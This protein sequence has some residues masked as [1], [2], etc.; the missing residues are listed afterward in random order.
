MAGSILRHSV[1]LGYACCL[2]LF[3]VSAVHAD[4]PEI[5]AEAPDGLQEAIAEQPETADL[6]AEAEHE[7]PA[8]PSSY[9]K[10]SGRI[11]KARS[12]FVYART[13]VGT[14]TLFSDPGLRSARAGQTVTL[15]T[16]DR[17]VVVDLHNKGEPTPILRLISGTPAHTSPEQQEV[18]FWTPEGGQL[19]PL[20]GDRGKLAPR[21]DGAPVTLQLK[22]SGE[23]VELPELHVDI[24]IS[25]GTRKRHE[26]SMKLAG[27]V[28][29]VKAGFAFLE[30]PI[31]T[32]TLSKRTGFR[33]ARAG[34]EVRV[35]LNE[36]YLVIDVHKEGGA[37]RDHRFITGKI[38]YASQDKNEIRLWTPE[39][40]TT[41]ALPRGKKTSH[42]FREGTP[43]TVHFNGSGEVIDV[44][45]A[46]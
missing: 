17:N 8:E 34:Q 29:R 43:I 12:G 19:V 25:N 36:H 38:V 30:T 20:D 46:G 27:T 24:Q 40:E 26:T 31:G 28:M 16:H 15:W 14:L 5:V 4:P 39:G 32:L 7:A 41:V 23:V 13:P 2:G 9:T 18:R 33:N 44:R 45:K 11:W 1:I 37:V 22:R 42:R 35:W 10:L 6:S 21:E 3:V